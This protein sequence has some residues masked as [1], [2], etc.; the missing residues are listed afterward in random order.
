MF[1][2][3]EKGAPAYPPKVMLNSIFYGYCRGIISSRPMEYACKT[4]GIVK[5]LAWDADAD[6]IAHFISS[7]AEAVKNLFAQVLCQ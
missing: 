7:Q 1:H 3:D 6:T 5:A 2:H 4:N